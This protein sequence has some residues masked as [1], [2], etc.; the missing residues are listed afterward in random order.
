MST[1]VEL[2]AAAYRLANLD[3]ELTS[4]ATTQEFPYNN[5]LYFLNAVIQEMNRLGAYWF[6]ET[7]TNLTYSPGVYQYNLSALNI[8]PQKILRVRRE[9]VTQAG[10]LEQWNWRRFQQTYRRSALLTTVPSVFSKYGGHLE[11]NCIPDQDYTLKVYHLRDM[12]KLS[13]TTDTLLI[14]DAD[15]DVIIDGVHA[16]LLQAMGRPDWGNY[17]T[18]FIEKSR[19]LL[20]DM[21]QDM[22]LPRQMPANF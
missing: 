10:E 13:A 8:D 1:A 21:K 3:Q 18:Q 9:S 14:P 11:L 12:P 2:C 22:G 19:S 4:F 20:A 15:E 5:A 16:K 17:Y 6:T 7:T